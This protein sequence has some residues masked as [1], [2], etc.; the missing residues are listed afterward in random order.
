MLT[1]NRP[2]VEYFFGFDNTPFRNRMLNEFR[3]PIE[4]YLVGP[5]TDVVALDRAR[6]QIE[7]MWRGED[8][9]NDRRCAE[10]IDAIDTALRLEPNDRYLT[11]LLA[12]MLDR[13]KRYEE[14]R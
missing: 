3:E 7:L 1:D 9:F 2:V 5:V 4:N 14:S 12:Q 6:H 11:Y 8:L 13:S 10:A